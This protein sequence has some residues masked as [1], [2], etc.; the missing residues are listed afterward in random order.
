MLE[1]KR[2]PADVNPVWHNSFSIHSLNENDTIEFHV[3]DYGV[4]ENNHVGGLGPKCVGRTSWQVGGSG[5]EGW[6][7]MIMPAPMPP[8]CGSPM[9]FLTIRPAR[10]EGMLPAIGTVSG[11]A[12]QLLAAAGMGPDAAQAMALEAKAPTLML[13]DAPAPVQE[14]AASGS[15][16]VGEQRGV[17]EAK[18][19]KAASGSRGDRPISSESVDTAA[20][21]C[22]GSSGGVDV[23][24]LDAIGERV[25]RRHLRQGGV[26]RPG[27]LEQIMEEEAEISPR[28]SPRG[29]SSEEGDPVE[30]SGSRGDP[31]VAPS[32]V[33]KE[34]RSQVAP[35]YNKASIFYISEHMFTWEKLGVQVEKMVEISKSECKHPFPEDLWYKPN[36]VALAFLF[37]GG[38]G[39]EHVLALLYFNALNRVQCEI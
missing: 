21:G 28:I 22:S 33:F 12:N 8:Y 30:E 39:V 23:H 14:E 10:I 38:L 26:L 3:M 15:G 31:G 17:E 1:T 20:S 27:A 11:I 36:A 37:R 5:C 34:S 24:P 18:E 19:E 32:R 4:L 35:G 29:P 9:L 13:T 7:E 16:G 2:V 25:L 6:L